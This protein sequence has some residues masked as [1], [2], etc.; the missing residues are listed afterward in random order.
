[1]II[2]NINPKFEEIETCV[3]NY[4]TGSSGRGVQLSKKI[5]GFSTA[6]KDHSLTGKFLRCRGMI[7]T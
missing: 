6:V 5:P 2:K 7:P 3:V 4:N 1:M